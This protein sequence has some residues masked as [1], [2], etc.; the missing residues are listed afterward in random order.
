LLLGAAFALRHHFGGLEDRLRTPD[1][2][3]Y[4]RYAGAVL[5]RGFSAVATLVSQYNHAPDFWIYP[6]PTRFGYYIL[7]AAASKQAQGAMSSQANLSIFFA[8]I[9]LAFLWLTAFR[10]F[11]RSTAW[12][13]AILM[14]FSPLDLAVSRR[15]WAD[16][17]LFCVSTLLI[18]FGMEAATASKKIGSWA[19]FAA[20]AFF[21]V[22][23]KESAWISTGLLILWAVTVGIGQNRKAALIG[24][25]LSALAL[26][27]GFAALGWAGG[28]MEGC[29]E[30][31]RHVQQSFPHN[32]Y[33]RQMQGG[34]WWF[35]ILGFWILS[36]APT[37]LFFLGLVSLVISARSGASGFFSP[38]NRFAALGLG[39]AFAILILS[40]SSVPYLK[41]LRFL[42]PFYG[43]Y[44]LFAG[45]GVSFVFETARVR[46][47]SFY[48]T[49]A[50]GAIVVLLVGFLA[51]DLS[52]FRSI[53]IEGKAAD[54]VVL[55]M[56]HFVDWH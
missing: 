42:S 4:S 7:L 51:T 22:W 46:L 3:I 21:S 49:V 17:P 50:W 2:Q 48:R 10:F 39:I 37:I 13:S 11:G 5:D 30:A 20:L 16:V 8:G 24:G 40:L 33:A 55:E 45:L 34:P 43:V 29:F 38:K 31:L 15:I 23:V 27:G 54:L 9:S 14:V 47:R 53:F 1:E 12:F 32:D 6:P 18:Y 36:P 19:C 26:A 35:F 25:A 28:G 44:Y 52:R 56:G 41:N